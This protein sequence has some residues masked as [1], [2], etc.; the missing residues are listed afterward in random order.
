MGVAV[1]ATSSAG[2]LE[3]GGAGQLGASRH[4]ATATPTALPAEPLLTKRPPRTICGVPVPRWA[5]RHL[6]MSELTHSKIFP[7]VHHT[8]DRSWFSLADL[9]KRS[10]CQ[11]PPPRRRWW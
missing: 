9:L 4:G 8:S 5:S 3:R 6:S 11:V 7:L 1:P 2:R 10:T